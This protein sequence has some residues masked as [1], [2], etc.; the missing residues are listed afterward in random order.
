MKKYVEAFGSFINGAIVM[1]VILGIIG[2]VVGR[3]DSDQPS[4]K[5]SGMRPRRDALTGCEYLESW[6]GALTPRMGSDGRQV[7]R[8]VEKP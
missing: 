3:D 6:T 8:G 5:R 4:G 1:L 7:C 2:V